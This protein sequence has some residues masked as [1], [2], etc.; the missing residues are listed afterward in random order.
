VSITEENLDMED[1]EDE[2]GCNHDESKD[3]EN[4]L[5]AEPCQEGI[6]FGTFL[7]RVL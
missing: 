4:M 2:M 1:E 5:F 3:K 6:K 7:V